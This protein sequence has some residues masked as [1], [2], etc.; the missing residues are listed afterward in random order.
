MTDLHTHLLV[1]EMLLDTLL[2]N[3]FSQEEIE[4]QGY[5]EHDVDTM[6]SMIKYWE[7]DDDD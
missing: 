3:G 2:D 5:L 7:D 4:E 1:Q 6:L